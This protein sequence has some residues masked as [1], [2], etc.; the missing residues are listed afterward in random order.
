[1]QKFYVFKGKWEKFVKQKSTVSYYMLKKKKCF[2]ITQVSKWSLVEVSGEVLLY[3]YWTLTLMVV[4]LSKYSS[5]LRF[6]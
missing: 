4:G 5:C 3:G 1:M 2:G 6:L